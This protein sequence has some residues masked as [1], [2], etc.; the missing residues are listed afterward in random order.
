MIRDL[1]TAEAAK[2]AGVSNATVIRWIDAGVLAGYRIPS[3]RFRRVSKLA[4]YE[5]M[6]SHGMPLDR[7][8]AAF[9]ELV[10]DRPACFNQLPSVLSE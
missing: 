7:F 10:L 1:T 4:L 5:L 8:K 3:T 6:V 2:I 9:P